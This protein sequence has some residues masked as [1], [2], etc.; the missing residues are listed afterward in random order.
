MQEVEILV[1]I[2]DNK[3]AVLK[4]LKQFDFAGIKKTLDVYFYNPDRD[5]LK[6]DKN[7]RLR[8]CFR[9]R[10]TCL[11]GRREDNKNYLTY[12][13]DYFDSDVWSHSDEHEVEVDDFEATLKIIEHLGF[14]ILVKIENEKH[15]F[16]TDNYEIVFEDVKGLGLFLEVERLKVDNSESISEIKKEIW[17]FIKSLNIQI[18]EELNAGKPELMLRKKKFVT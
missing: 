11:T 17:N 18:G 5:E 13:I 15:T 6:P 2:L 7:N 16:L 3:Q 9:L 12:K 1:N 4:K 8:Q 14:K 10:K